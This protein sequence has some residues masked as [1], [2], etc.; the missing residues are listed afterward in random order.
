MAA[1]QHGIAREYIG[2]LLNR[3]A[4][5]AAEATNATMNGMVRTSRELP[6]PLTAR[7]LEVLRLLE[8]GLL[9]RQIADELVISLGTVKRHTANIY[10]KLGV[11]TRTQAL[12]RARRLGLL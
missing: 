1:A 4:S 3:L 6:K 2:H 8:S 10:G 7:E 11:E 9:N 12:S 5:S